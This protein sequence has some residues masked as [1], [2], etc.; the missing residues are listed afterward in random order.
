[1][2]SYSIKSQT[3]NVFSDTFSKNVIMSIEKIEI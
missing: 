3:L 2:I 1:M